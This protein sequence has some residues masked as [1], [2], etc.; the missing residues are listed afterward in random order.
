MAPM[1]IEIDPAKW[2]KE[3]RE[4]LTSRSFWVYV[5][6]AAFIPLLL[7]DA[8]ADFLGIT[9]LRD[10]LRPWLGA[11]ALLA[12]IGLG[13]AQ[14]MRVASWWEGKQ[15]V[16]KLFQRLHTLSPEEKRMLKRYIA[17]QTKTQ[18]ISVMDGI[19]GGLQ[20]MGI[21]YRPTGMGDFVEGFAFNIQPWAW[22]H[23]QKHP[24]L[25]EGAA[26]EEQTGRRRI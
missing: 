26:P 12:L 17:G 10:A 21:L 13:V 19:A 23:L 22:D 9:K 1:P 16:Q 2:V 14:G 4:T 15:K 3:L 20:A 6:L 25:L 24:E 8:A 7:P 18:Y 5:F 11:A